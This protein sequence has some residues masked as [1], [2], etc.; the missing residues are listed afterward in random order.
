MLTTDLAAYLQTAGVGTVGTDIFKGFLPETPNDCVVLFQRGGQPPEVV[1]TVPRIEYPELH[2]IIRADGDTAYEDAMD[3][4]N[5]VMVALHAIG[6]VTINTRRYLYV[7]ALSSP[8]L[9][10]YD[11][12]QKPPHVYV[13]IDFQVFK[14]VEA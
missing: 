11:Y 5:D 10:R 8:T 12:S 14:E 7:R 3:K 4:A 9:M 13:A 6:E 1:N 2:V